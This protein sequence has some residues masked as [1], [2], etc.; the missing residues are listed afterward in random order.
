MNINIVK[1]LKFDRNETCSQGLSHPVYR[2]IKYAMGLK[3]GEGI[4]VLVNDD[5]WASVIRNIAAVKGLNV[6]DGGREGEFLRLIL[7]R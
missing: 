1:T 4:L 3:P 6:Q 5:D 2:V 7:Y